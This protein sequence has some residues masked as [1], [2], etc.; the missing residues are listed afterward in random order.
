M[1]SQPSAVDEPPSPV[2]ALAAFARS[3]AAT[4]ARDTDAVAVPTLEGWVTLHASLPAG[5]VDGRVAIVLERSA[6]PQSTA[7]RLE[8]DG[9]T[10]GSVRSRC[11]WRRA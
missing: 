5:G 4:A 11:C 8:A 9:V 1:A 10:P 3:Q 2:L 6:S 7:V